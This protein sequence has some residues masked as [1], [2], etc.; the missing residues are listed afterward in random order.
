MVSNSGL[1]KF[2][3]AVDVVRRDYSKG[4]TEQNL[5]VV[6]RCVHVGDYD[7][8]GQALR[9]LQRLGGAGTHEK[10]RASSLATHV[11]KR[12]VSVGESINKVSLQLRSDARLLEFGRLAATEVR[13][14]L[15]ATK[16]SV[17]KHA[18]QQQC[19]GELYV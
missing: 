8:W 18:Q 12:N 14:A 4:A 2:T 17:R 3:P 11:P 13:A 6:V 15:H 5:A 19:R 10:W 1:P 16:A 7:A 9:R